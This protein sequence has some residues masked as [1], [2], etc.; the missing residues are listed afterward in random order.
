MGKNEECLSD[1]HIQHSPTS[2]QLLALNKNELSMRIHEAQIINE[3]KKNKNP[4]KNRQK[5]NEWNW[6]HFL[7]F[8]L[9]NFMTKTNCDYFTGNSIDRTAELTHLSPLSVS[10]IFSICPH[11]PK[12]LRLFSFRC[13]ERTNGEK[14]WKLFSIWWAQTNCV[15]TFK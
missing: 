13:Y 10:L 3:R 6:M 15:L 14:C 12:N 7:R 8:V 4:I 2:Q 5:G 11:L 9:I 1:T